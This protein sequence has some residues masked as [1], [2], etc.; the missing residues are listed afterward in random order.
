VDGSRQL[1]SAVGFVEEGEWLVFPEGAPTT[2]LQAAT[3]QLKA[4]STPTPA[5]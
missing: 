4:L 2:A 1:L 5:P 3:A